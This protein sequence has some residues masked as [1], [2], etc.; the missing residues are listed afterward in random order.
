MNDLWAVLSVI[1]L[2]AGALLATRKPIAMF[3]PRARKMARG[4]RGGQ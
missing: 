3:Q 4:P 2:L 1:A